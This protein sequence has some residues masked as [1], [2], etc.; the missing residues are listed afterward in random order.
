MNVPV[1]QRIS[2]FSLLCPCN[3]YFRQNNRQICELCT[4]KTKWYSVKFKCVYHSALYSFIKSAAI[5]VQNFAGIRKK[6]SRFIFPSTFTMNKFIENGF[7]VNKCIY[8][9]TPFN[10]TVI[11][12]DLQRSIS[13]L[14]YMSVEP[15]R[16]KA[17]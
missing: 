6:I 7:D 16:I 9:P 13:L 3:I 8:I 14:P 2:D 5:T 11:R 17:S 10:D 4:Q 15:T 1:I 12:S